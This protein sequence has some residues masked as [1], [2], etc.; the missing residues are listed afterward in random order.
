[1]PCKGNL[2]GHDSLASDKFRGR[3]RDTGTAFATI[4]SQTNRNKSDPLGQLYFRGANVYRLEEELTL[5][6]VVA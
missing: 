4:S 1:M 6:I 2:P 5:Q 3:N